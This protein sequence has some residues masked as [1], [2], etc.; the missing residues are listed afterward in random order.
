[1]CKEHSSAQSTPW[2]NPAEKEQD[3]AENTVELMKG[4]IAD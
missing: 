1:M 4:V 2:K 3:A